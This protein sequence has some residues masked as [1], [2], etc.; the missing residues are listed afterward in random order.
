MAKPKI[1]PRWAEGS[2][3]NII[4]E[5]AIG[6][7]KSQVLFSA[8]ELDIFSLIGEDKKNCCRISRNSRSK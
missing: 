3:Y 8:V 5:I 7:Q 1:D 2:A 6:F 4:Q